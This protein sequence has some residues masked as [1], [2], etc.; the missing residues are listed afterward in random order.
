MYVCMYE[1]GLF[2]CNVMDE[3]L[4]IG[5][6]IVW[7]WGVNVKSESDISYVIP[8]GTIAK[9]WTRSPWLNQSIHQP[10]DRR[11]GALS[12]S[13]TGRTSDEC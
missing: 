10:S 1:A 5:T 9:P 2:Q 4:V 6:Q 11:P 7:L 13:R 8:A 12:I 3:M